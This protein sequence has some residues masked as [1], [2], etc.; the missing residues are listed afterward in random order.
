MIKEV[1]LDLDCRR[2]AKY[3]QIEGI[4]L[5]AFENEKIHPVKVSSFLD[6]M[7][8]LSDVTLELDGKKYPTHKIILANNSWKLFKQVEKSNEIQFKGLDA[9]LFQKFIEY[10]YTGSIVIDETKLD[11]YLLLS[12]TL[13][14]SSIKKECFSLMMKGFD[15][16]NVIPQLIKSFNKEFKYDSSEL[17][18]LCFKYVEDKCYE[19]I[20]SDAWIKLPPA[21]M[22]D[23]LL[24]SRLV[25]DELDLFNGLRR[26]GRENKDHLKD[27]A[28][29]IRYTQI[30]ID[31]LKNVIKKSELCPNELYEEALE[32]HKNPDKFSKSS[33]LQFLPRGMLLFGTK[34]LSPSQGALII[35][36]VS[37]V[38][39]GKKWK[40][41][42]QATRDGFDTNKFH[43]LCD[44]FSESIIVIKAESGNIFG[45][46]SAE[47][48]AGSGYSNNPKTFLFSVQNSINQP[49]VLKSKGQSNETYRYSSYGP[50]FGSGHDL[51]ICSNSNTTNSSYTNNPYSF[52]GPQ[53][54]TGTANTFLAGS[55][56]FKTKEIEVYGLD[57]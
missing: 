16:E 34:I 21:I 35:K 42:Y 44:K 43:S 7:S 40:L 50:T 31:D 9:T 5:V 15:K 2:D 14:F 8:T 45:A 10:M 12:D 26:W 33:D 17:T 55:Y 19:V 46:Y 29:Y 49:Q 57:K 37:E 18:A 23:L 52:N 41:A 30:G 1:R 56:N 39:K 32:F 13:G 4:E 24:S 25:V 28:Q 20:D 51:Y 22:K 54:F 48:W 27:Y 6:N 11:D 47:T 36:W 3:T 38:S 53:N